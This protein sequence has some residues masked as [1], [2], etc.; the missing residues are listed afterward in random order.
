METTVPANIPFSDLKLTK[1]GETWHLYRHKKTK[2]KLWWE[3]NSKTKS[4]K[5]NHY[6][7]DL[8]SEGNFLGICEYEP[9]LTFELESSLGNFRGGTQTELMK[10]FPE[11][12]DRIAELCR[13]IDQKIVLRVEYDGNQ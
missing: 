8:D 3:Y 10:S 4:W 11:I 12:K 5:W 13:K 7:D 1:K 2:A 6:Y 9:V